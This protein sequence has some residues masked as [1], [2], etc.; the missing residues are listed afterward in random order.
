MT[1]LPT[2]LL[3]DDETTVR[4]VVA[5]MLSDSGFQVM[6]ASSGTDALRIIYQ[7]SIDLLFTDIIMP[8]IDGVELAKRA[9]QV[10]PELKVLFA[11]GY[12]QKAFERD[13]IRRGRVIYKPFRREQLLAEVESALAA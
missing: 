3:V 6:T 10:R 9:R 7:R 4:E 5:Q 2:I 1:A 8:G 12:A 13:A 11:T